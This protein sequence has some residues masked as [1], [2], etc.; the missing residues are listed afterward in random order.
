MTHELN[1]ETF[2]FRLIY[3]GI[4]GFFFIALKYQ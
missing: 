4:K 3:L 1:E 2:S